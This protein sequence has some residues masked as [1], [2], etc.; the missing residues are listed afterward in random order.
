MELQL[1]LVFSVV[2]QFAAFIT[3]IS[4]IPKTRFNIAWIS[5]SIGFLLMAFRRLLEAFYLF[6]NSPLSNM[7]V[8]NSW[9]AVFI[10][11]TMLV[12]SVYIRKIFKVLNRIQKMR[13]ENETRLLSAVISAEERER[14]HFAKEIH[15]GLG[16][17]LSFA[18][19][20]LSAMEKNDMKPKNLMLLQKVE[21]IV[22]NAI[23]STKE[24][25][26]LLTPHVLERFGLRKA[27]DTFVGNLEL[28]DVPQFDVA[29]HLEQKRYAPNL[30]IIL[31]RICCELVNNTLKYA[32]AYK[33]IISIKENNDYLLFYYQDDGLGFDVSGHRTKGMGLTNIRSRVKSLNGS[34]AM[35][36]VPNQG[37][38]AKIKLPL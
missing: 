14:K 9:V 27:V 35:N 12:S 34:I 19:M 2:F 18:K 16:P 7:T 29:Y 8:I 11:V 23:V 31:Y 38:W 30:E 32:Q 37:F 28:K 26:G 33:I 21:Q 25:S 36:S 17:V 20:T 24:I 3:I 4:L 13:K 5:I 6:T 15:D 10:S 1:A 22:D